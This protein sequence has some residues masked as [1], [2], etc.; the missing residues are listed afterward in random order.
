MGFSEPIRSPIRAIVKHPR[1]FA[2]TVLR[3]IMAY[4]P[5][6]MDPPHLPYKPL[7]ELIGGIETQR[8][9]LSHKVE[10][11]S[12]PYGEAYVLAA[13]AAAL[14]P[15]TVFEIGTFTGGATLIMAQQAGTACRVFTLD[16]PPRQTQLRLRGLAEDPP[17]SNAALIGERFRGTAYADQITQL[18]GDSAT[19]DYTPFKGTIDLVLVDGSHSYDYV[20]ND[21]RH[22]LRLLSRGGTIVWDDCSPQYPGVMR[23]LNELGAVRPVYRLPGTRFAIY[24]GGPGER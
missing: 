7:H 22:A 5:I 3:F 19:F 15:R 12:L 20:K 21:T 17:E 24:G 14:R 2:A 11:K 6:V 1:R 4:D 10:P 9:C 18:Y 8:V 23:A 13:I 16:M